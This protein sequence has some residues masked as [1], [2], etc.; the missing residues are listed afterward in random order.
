MLGEV[1]SPDGETI[2]QPAPSAERV[3]DDLISKGA[4]NSCA[5]KYRVT[6]NVT[7]SVSVDIAIV[8]QKK[9]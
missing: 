7:A 9:A 5:P 3:P 6:N 4:S 1:I 8:R 2:I